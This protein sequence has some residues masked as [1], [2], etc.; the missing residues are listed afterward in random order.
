[1]RP[2][3]AEPL[4][5]G[6]GDHVAGGDELADPLDHLRDRAA[7]ERGRAVAGDA[8]RPVRERH[9]PAPARGHGAFGHHHDA[10]HRGG[11][12]V[13]AGGLVEHAVGLRARVQVRDRLLADQRSRRPVRQRRGHRVEGARLSGRSSACSASAAPPGAHEHERERRRSRRADPAAR[14]ATPAPVAITRPPCTTTP[15]ELRTGRVA[16]GKRGAAEQEGPDADNHRESEHGDRR[17]GERDHPPDDGRQTPPTRRAS[18]PRPAPAP[19]PTASPAPPD[20]QAGA[21]DDRERRQAE[22]GPRDR[23]QAGEHPCPAGRP[24]RATAS[25][26]DRRTPNSSAPLRSSARP[27]TRRAPRAT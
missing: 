15:P 16:S 14:G 10:A 22:P 24:G 20:E 26:C 13:E 8:H 12:A 25:A 3:R 7:L 6:R 27:T 4:V 11:A 5:V 23:H 19:P 9:D 18:A 17:P 2:G 21:G 1:M